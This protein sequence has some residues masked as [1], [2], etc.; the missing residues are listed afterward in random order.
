MKKNNQHLDELMKALAKDAPQFD[1]TILRNII[2]DPSSA[3]SNILQEPTTPS[4]TGVLIMSS[5]L[6]LLTSLASLFYFNNT[7][8]DSPKLLSQTTNPSITKNPHTSTD[9]EPLSTIPTN[10]WLD[11]TEFPSYEPVDLS[12]IVPYVLPESD[13]YKLG[14]AKGDRNTIYTYHL[15]CKFIFPS[16]SISTNTYETKDDP[17]VKTYGSM[18]I[19]PSFATDVNGNL[20]LMYEYQKSGNG[21][22][23]SVAFPEAMSKQNLARD[24]YRISSYNSKNIRV[25]S[26]KTPFRVLNSVTVRAGIMKIDTQLWHNAGEQRDKVYDAEIK[27]LMNAVVERDS[28]FKMS[29]GGERELTRLFDF[30][31][32]HK[33][34][35][36][37]SFESKLLK[38]MDSIMST[39]KST[40]EKAK[41][42]IKFLDN[43][44]VANTISDTT[45]LKIEQLSRHYQYEE[46]LLGK[47]EEKVKIASMNQL[48]P[49]LVRPMTG[50]KLDENYNNGLILWYQPSERLRSAL[51]SLATPT[52][53]QKQKN[54]TIHT[55]VF[56]NPAP[57]MAGAAFIK[58]DLAESAVLTVDMYDISGRLVQQ[59][60][61][62]PKRLKG[63]Y[64]DEFSLR[65]IK[66]GMYVLR[67]TTD[68]GD[69]RYERLIVQ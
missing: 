6:I 14:I 53:L 56:P 55:S 38:S 49:I 64:T 27:R 63:S 30:T 22:V 5:I 36:A 21:S 48:I 25:D 32:Q 65:D 24:Y 39:T 42:K 18:G 62:T 3:P 17:L 41:A 52:T 8:V 68:N 58:T 50:S 40:K 66:S 16:D 12:S 23:M 37:Q 4:K 43:L 67:I 47:D 15:E 28:V 26:A 44:I 31:S 7:T 60:L 45:K 2:A 10:N 9:A 51:P 57:K 59:L 20:I 1:R 54:S 69:Q 46:Y 35:P 61:I 19:F 34:F 29:F 13:F 11:S 33:V